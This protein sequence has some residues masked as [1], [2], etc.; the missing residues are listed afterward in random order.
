[1]DLITPDNRSPENDFSRYDFTIQAGLDGLLFYAS[2]E[3]TGEITLFNK[4]PFVT[5]K[6]NLLLRKCREIFSGQADRWGKFRTTTLYLPEPVFTLVPEHLFS[7][8]V[9][10]F[11]LTGADKPSDEKEV[12]LMQYHQTKAVLAFSPGR[13]LTRFFTA[14]FPGCIITHELSRILQLSQGINGSFLLFS[15][16]SSWFFCTLFNNSRLEAANCCRFR[17]NADLLFFILSYAKELLHENIPVYLSGWGDGFEEKQLLIKKYLPKAIEFQ[18]FPE[19]N[20]SFLPIEK[21]SV[22]V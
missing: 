1:M 13:N 20:N 12:I 21:P 22:P 3:D 19:K 16:H 17:D 8:R 5:G 6:E 2:R 10:N 14:T 7:G 9:V 15:L 11:N 18:I 4:F